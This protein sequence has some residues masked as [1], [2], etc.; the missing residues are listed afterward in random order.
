MFQCGNNFLRGNMD[1]DSSKQEQASGLFS[2]ELR[3]L[4]NL[5]FIDISYAHINISKKHIKAVSSNYLWHLRYWEN[6][7]DKKLD[8]RL[9]PGIKKWCS[10]DNS[11]LNILEDHN[12][13]KISK[14]D[15]TIETDEGY[16]VI[17]INSTDYS[18]I[19]NF[20]VNYDSTIFFRESA[21]KVFQRCGEEIALPIRFSCERTTE[22][23]PSW[24]N[25]T[26]IERDTIVN[27]TRLKTVKEIALLH[28]CSESC[29]RKRIDKI[30]EK[31]GCTGFPLSK[32]FEKVEWKKII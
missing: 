5:Q 27:L 20:L 9:S 31:L 4:L 19:N 32:V 22:G 14:I 7:F 10:Y 17:S 6:D 2:S 24:I 16:E 26:K 13:N 21:N 11:Y 23:V 30:R 12:T 3:K 28:K 15:L 1:I 25:L 8:Q 18:I 29:E